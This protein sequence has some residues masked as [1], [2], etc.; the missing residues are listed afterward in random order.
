MRTR[1]GQRIVTG[2]VSGTLTPSAGTSPTEIGKLYAGFTYALATAVELV[3]TPIVFFLL[4]RFLDDRFGSGPVIAVTFASGAVLGVV[5]KMFYAYRAEFAR[6]E[7]GKPW[8]R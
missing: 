8:T 5:V 7:E 3:L 2:A 6:Q 4:G 1:G